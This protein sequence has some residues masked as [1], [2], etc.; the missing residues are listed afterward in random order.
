MKILFVWPN[1]DSFG[2]KPIGISLLSA[3]AK[4]LGWE[5]RLFDTSEFDFGFVDN[6]CSGESANFFKPVD[7]SKYGIQKRKLHLES[8]FISIIEKFDPNCLAFSVLS[9]EFLI[10]ARLSNIAK[11]V[12]PKLPIIWGGKYPTLN[13]QKTLNEF[14]VDFACVS[15]GID[16][17]SKFLN[18]L[19]IEGDLYHIQNIYAKKNGSIIKNKILPLHSNLDDLPYLDWEIYDK[20]QFY[21]PFDGNIYIGGDHMLNWGC[22]YHCSYCIN[23]FYHKTYNNKYSMRRYSIKRIIRELKYLKKKYSLK[24]FK[25]HDEDFLMRPI[26]NLRELST[27][28]RKEINLPFVIETNPKSVIKEKVKLLKEMNC[29]SVSVAIETGDINFRK[30]ILKRID[31]EN[32]IVMA[33][34]LFKDAGIRTSSFNLL[35]IPFETRRTFKK[36]INLNRKAQVQYPSINFFYPFEGTEL[37]DIAIEKGFF[38]PQDKNTLVYRRDKPALFFDNL[39]QDELVQMKETFVFYVKL[40]KFYELFIRRSEYSDVLGMRLRR[41]LLEIYRSTV[42]NHNGWYL[43]DGLKNRYLFELGNILRGSNNYQE[44]PCDLCGSIDAVEAPHVRDYTEGQPIY[45]CKQCGFVYIKLRRTAEEISDIW[46][47]EIFSDNYTAK[48]PAVKSRQ[49]YVADFIDA[50]I[51][52]KGKRVCDI[53]TGEGQFLEIISQDRYGAKVFGI[54]ASKRNCQSL[55][56]MGIKHFNGTIEDYCAAR[57]DKNNKA[58]IVT[59]MWTLEACRSCKDMLSGAYQILKDNGYVVVATGSRILVPF[60]K[61]L[62]LYFG[63]NPADTHPFRFSANTLR[64]ILAVCGFNVIHL[65]RYIDS[66]VLC[67]I[68]KKQRRKIKIKW[69]GDNPLEVYNFFERWHKE[70]LFYPKDVYK[71]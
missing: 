38:D 58:D 48:I 42:L 53:G 68:A 33:F 15:E 71:E 43:D 54:E 24:F 25:F 3:I 51:T 52:L 39:T 55:T 16:A 56:G 41:K 70:T 62:Y 61:P 46:S 47:N 21:K 13:P 67:V 20:R 11:K 64:G 19:S 34:S 14:K 40:P 63:K 29:V 4:K 36:T 59:I 37:R 2:F 30:N 18:A 28:Y 22:P 10:A 35:G 65:N 27:A 31:S 17:F 6:T 69:Q 8:N 60:K 66:D 5:V 1:K 50:K 57:K 49:M 7:L 44:F 9:D 45:I 26:E 32:D 12:R 23:H